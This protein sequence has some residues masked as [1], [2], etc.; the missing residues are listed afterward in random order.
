MKLLKKLIATAIITASVIVSTSA[1]SADNN[2]ITGK[3]EDPSISVKLVTQ[4]PWY[5]RTILRKS[6][7]EE[8]AIDFR[9]AFYAGFYR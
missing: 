5:W 2:V 3:G 9:S 8:Q 1:V 4:Y 7:L 6:Y